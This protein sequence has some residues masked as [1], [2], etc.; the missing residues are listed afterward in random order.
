MKRLSIRDGESTREFLQ[1]L[2]ETINDPEWAEERRR[3]RFIEDW[4]KGKSGKEQ[5]RQIGRKSTPGA[6]FH[7]PEEK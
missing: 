4:R 3:E 7:S 1:H 6:V 5:V 2:K